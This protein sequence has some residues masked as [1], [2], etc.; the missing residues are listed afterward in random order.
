M[1]Q[2]KKTFIWS[3]K[4]CQSH[5]SWPKLC[6]MIAQ[7]QLCH[8]VRAPGSTRAV[9]T[10]TCDL[11]VR[12]T[13]PLSLNWASSGLFPRLPNCPLLCFVFF[14]VK[15]LWSLSQSR[16]LNDITQHECWGRLSHCSPHSSHFVKQR[17]SCGL[18][19]CSEHVLAAANTHTHT[20]KYLIWS[21]DR[22][23]HCLPRSGRGACGGQREPADT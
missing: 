20:S 4:V 12:D 10:Q 13:H 21:H 14:W 16:G 7:T 17:A 8:H 3:G 11:C 6:H 9:W 18:S 5:R 23:G 1:A 22:C 15:S 19:L 2:T